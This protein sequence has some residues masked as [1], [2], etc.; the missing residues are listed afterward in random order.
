MYE[1]RHER[2]RNQLLIRERTMREKLTPLGLDPAI[3]SIPD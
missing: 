3:E 1:K 2:E